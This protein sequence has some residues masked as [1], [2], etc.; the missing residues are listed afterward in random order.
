MSLWKKITGQFVDVIEWVDDSRDTLIWKFPD[1][2]KE[3]KMGAQLTVRPGQAAIFVNEGTLADVLTEGR[4]ELATRNLPILTTLKSWKHGF[5]SPFKVDIYFV[6]LKQFSAMKW[7][8]PQPI[9]INDPDFMAVQLRA[10]GSFSFKITDPASFFRNFAA[11]DPHVTTEEVMTHFRS[12]V[13]SE[14]SNSLK[15]SGKSIAEINMRAG[16]L[17]TDLLP[18]LQPDFAQLGLELI[19]FTVDSVSLPEEIQK[20]L[21]A[22]DLEYRKSKRS[23]TLETEVDLQRKMNDLQVLMAKA[24]LSQ[25]V[26][27][28][29]KFMQMQA[30][31][32]MDKP[33]TPGSDSSNMMN[34]MMQM[35]MS[36][37][38]AQQMMQQM[39]GVMPAAAPQAPTP[40]APA[41]GGSTANMSRDEAMNMLKQLGDLKAAG[42]LTEDEFNAKK[43]ELLAKL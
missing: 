19:R 28:M 31:L 1:E 23:M 40:A 39:Q 24:N 38:M 3:I 41:A 37:Q 7:G 5:D 10:N 9:I 14:F 34:Q 4:H 13:V 35:G 32:G 20:E 26:G 36:M 6:S 18:I 8:T 25:N 11:S 43:Q 29:Q 42:I 21:N 30:A 2:D 12:I 27:D 22:Q 15:K 16:E 17:G 33:G